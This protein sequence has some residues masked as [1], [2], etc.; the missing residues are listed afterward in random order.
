MAEKYSLLLDAAKRSGFD[1]VIADTRAGLDQISGGICLSSE[2]V[3]VIMEQDRVSWRS[4]TS[5]GVNVIDLHGNHSDARSRGVATD[6]LFYLPNKVSQPFAQAL[7]TA[8]ETSGGL[9]L[10][11]N[12]LMG[13]PFDL[14]FFTQYLRNSFRFKPQGSSWKSSSFYRFL[15]DSMSQ[16]LPE[17]E[18]VKYPKWRII[19]EDINMAFQVPATNFARH[20]FLW[21]WIIALV[22]MAFLMGVFIFEI[23]RP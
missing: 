22:Y 21:V 20:G 13:I 10:P 14:V 16:V 9:G 18:D 1:Y 2:F 23:L 5:F 7:R 17:L 11:G 12:S 3:I 6:N 4:S 15:R 8:R 19:I